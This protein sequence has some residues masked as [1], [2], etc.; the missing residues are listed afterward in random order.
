MKRV[1]QPFDCVTVN[2]SRKVGCKS[3][4]CALW[5]FAQATDDMLYVAAVNALK[6]CRLAARYHS[7]NRRVC[8]WN[9]AHSRRLVATSALNQ[10]LGS[11]V[12]L[13]EIPHGVG[14]LEH[15]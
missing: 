6:G 5:T 7:D 12:Q 11:N 15:F 2:I 13:I 14:V 4:R 3:D 9:A 1:Q 8:I 10:A